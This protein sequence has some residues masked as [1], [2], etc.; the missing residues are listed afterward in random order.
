[1]TDFWPS[2]GSHYYYIPIIIQFIKFNSFNFCWS[3]IL[4]LWRPDV[5]PDVNALHPLILVLCFS[6]SYQKCRNLTTWSLL[7]LLFTFI[8]TCNVKYSTITEGTEKET[9]SFMNNATIFSQ[10]FRYVFSSPIGL[11]WNIFSLIY[12]S[13]MKMNA[14]RRFYQSNV[15]N[16]LHSWTDYT[17]S[18]RNCGFWFDV[19]HF[20]RVR[21]CWQQTVNNA[22]FCAQTK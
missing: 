8:I 10:L 22:P 15:P 14:K 20:S 21:W 2:F 13:R 11:I 1:M 6:C 18:V 7:F 19:L 5:L 17:L 9:S 16:W 12:Y 4:L 3:K